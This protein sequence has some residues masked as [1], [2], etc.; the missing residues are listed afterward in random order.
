MKTTKKEK[1]TPWPFSAEDPFATEKQEMDSKNIENTN[2]KNLNT[3]KTN[4]TS[5]KKAPVTQKK[6]A[7]SKPIA[8]S[9]KREAAERAKLSIV[10]VETPGT[11]T[12][13]GKPEPVTQLQKTLRVVDELA[14]KVKQRD[15][16]VET[17]DTLETFQ[18]DQEQKEGE[19]NGCSF[20]VRDDKGMSW[21]IKNVNFIVSMLEYGIQWCYAR[22][23]AIEKTIILPT[24]AA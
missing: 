14:R 22:K 24:N 15:V 18:I 17:I 13:P 6:S 1:R 2:S 23:E 3:M 19:Y 10:K 12:L 11:A 5:V 7:P 21:T 9:V 16:M 4:K 20:T 8:N